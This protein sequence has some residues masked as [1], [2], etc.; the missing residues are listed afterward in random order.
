VSR[1]LLV[2]DNPDVRLIV[3]HVLVDEGYEV[4]AAEN[5]RQGRALLDSQPYDLLLTDGKLPDGNGVDLANTATHNGIPALVMTGY[6]FI[7]RAL[8]PDLSRY[9]VLL[10]P[11]HPAEILEAVAGALAKPANC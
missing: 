5:L 4:D 10:K 9:R 3:E 2:E 8:A 6:A 11:L 7:L 1:I